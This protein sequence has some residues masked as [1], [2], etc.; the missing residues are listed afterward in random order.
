ME[1]PKIKPDKKHRK[2][3]ENYDVKLKIKGNLFDVLRV[4][5]TPK[6]DEN[7]KADK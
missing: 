4:A 6:P 7:E 3:K 5:V 1:E 2:R